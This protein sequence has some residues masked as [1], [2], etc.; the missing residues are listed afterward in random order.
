MIQCPICKADASEKYKLTYD[1]YQ[2]KK[3]N[4][5]FAPNA[6][7]NTSLVS[8]LDESSR[9]KALKNLRMLNFDRI[10]LA[11]KKY[12]TPSNTG[13]EIGCGH[14]WF[15][16]A[17][18]ENQIKCIGIEPETNFNDL[19]KSIGVEVLNG[20]FPDVLPV[21]T[22]YDFIAYNDV[23]EHLPDV[24]AMMKTNNALLNKNGKLIINLPIQG[25][26]TYFISGLA[27]Y[28][29]VKTLINR[30]WQFNFHSPHFSYF[31]KKNLIELAESADFKLIDAFA[32]KTI[33]IS[34]IKDRV[35]QDK[36]SNVISRYISI[37]GAFALYP[38][39]QLFPDTY[40][41]VFEKKS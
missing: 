28:F 29:G 32:L 21:N 33:N 15:L 26:V 5:Q 10:M 39:M 4:F 18:K 16:E 12:I 38:F 13:I 30:M 37:A 11:L 1:V 36:N 17:C 40:C 7:F 2:C 27:Y 34:E 20:F 6:R 8:D 35:N 19:H 23:F 22:Q 31:S 14:G 41:F 25:G 3:C 24:K 9:I